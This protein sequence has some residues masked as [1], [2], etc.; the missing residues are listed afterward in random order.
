MSSHYFQ[1]NSG[2]PLLIKL[3]ALLVA[4]YVAFLLL[5]VFAVVLSALFSVLKILVLVAVL[6]FA[7][8]FLLKVLFGI[9]VFPFNQ[10]QHYRYYRR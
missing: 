5:K 3:S 9:N 7:A 10:R 8:T 6:A 1:R 2:V 4:L